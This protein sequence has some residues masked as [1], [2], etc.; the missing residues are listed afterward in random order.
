[1]AYSQFKIDQRVIDCLGRLPLQ[2]RVCMVKAFGKIRDG[3]AKLL[4]DTIIPR[5]FAT[6]YCGHTILV[7]V[8]RDGATAVIVDVASARNPIAGLW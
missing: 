7:S 4:P 8:T 1:M 2:T 5:L 3:V 6:E